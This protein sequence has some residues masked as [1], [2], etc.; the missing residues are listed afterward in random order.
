MTQEN[1]LVLAILAVAV[2][3]FVSERLRVDLIAMMVLITLSL[4]GLVT[5][6]EAF[7]GFASPAVITVWS[8]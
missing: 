8:V 7:S 6:E 3:L 1:I 2:I 5:I 4:T